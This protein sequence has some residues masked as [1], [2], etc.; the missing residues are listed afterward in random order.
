ML[1]FIVKRLLLLIPMVI[2]ITLVSFFV[3]QLAPGDFLDAWRGQPQITPETIER[4]RREFGIVENP[5]FWQQAQQYGRWLLNAL[6]GD[7]GFS[8]DKKIEASEL[9][10]QR[11]YY[12]FILSFWSTVFAWMVGIPLG[13]YV[14]RNRNKFGDRVANFFAFAGISLPGFFIALLALKLAQET[15]WFPVGGAQSENYQSLSQWGKIKDTAWHMLLPVLVL[16]TRGVAGLMRQMRGNLLDVLSE[17]FVLAARARGLSERKVVYKH[18]VRNSINPLITLFGYELS[19][20]LAGAALV[21]TVLGWPGLGL[22][23]LESVR[24]QDLYVA[25]GAFTMGAVLLVLGNLVADVL[26]ALTDPRIKFE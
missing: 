9:I 23:L 8:F 26:L 12:T 4:M 17:N 21:E 7:F 13:I 3:M 24:S 14:A 1:R 6:Q 25:M 15:G 10:A 18:A 22:L 2:G 20:L 5:T 11:L 16:G 19:G